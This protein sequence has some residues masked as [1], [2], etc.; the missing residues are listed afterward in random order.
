MDM[1][2]IIVSITLALSFITIILLFLNQIEGLNQII[3]SEYIILDNTVTERGESEDFIIYV[4]VCENITLRVNIEGEVL[5]IDE[6]SCNLAVAAAYTEESGWH[7]FHHK[8]IGGGH[9]IDGVYHDG[10]KCNEITGAFIYANNHWKFVISDIEKIMQDATKYENSCAFAQTMLVHDNNIVPLPRKLLSGEKTL[11]R[12]LCDYHNSL[13]VVDSKE[14]LTMNE[15]ALK[16][17]NAG[18]FSALNLDMDTMYSK[19]REKEDDEMIDIHP[20]DD[21]TQFAT[22]YLLFHFL[23]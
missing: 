14:E 6:M 13:T 23:D 20:A 5:N 12:A 21:S 2:K 8:L 22:N 11:R 19:W 9:V 16:L 3:G 4:P 17:Q 15:F 10:F 18:I 7:N 1:K